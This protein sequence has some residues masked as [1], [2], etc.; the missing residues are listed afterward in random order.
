MQRC[1]EVS[2]RRGKT[3]SLPNAALLLQKRGRCS[4]CFLLMA[5]DRGGGGA[6]E[7][8]RIELGYPG[9]D[10]REGKW[11]ERERTPKTALLALIKRRT[12]FS[13]GFLKLAESGYIS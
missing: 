3:F 12:T 13:E 5:G 7:A 2:L 4:L 11:R 8:C 9:E 6:G 10:K 1:S